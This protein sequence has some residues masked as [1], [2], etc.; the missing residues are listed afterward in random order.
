[1]DL[2]C[3]CCMAIEEDSAS[4]DEQ[5]QPISQSVTL[6]ALTSRPGPC[7]RT[8]QWRCARCD[9]RSLVAASGEPLP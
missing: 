6:A 3:E 5:G 7:L 2:T 9:E 8:R 1:M 4:A